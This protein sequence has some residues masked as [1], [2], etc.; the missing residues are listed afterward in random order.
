MEMRV[1]VIVQARMSSARFPGKV[2]APLCG[3]PLIRHVCQRALIP[4]AS[5][6]VATSDDGMDD[7]IYQYVREILRVPVY[8]GSLNNPLERIL[9][10]AEWQEADYV[11]RITGDTPLVDSRT[12]VKIVDEIQN[13]PCEYVGVTNSPDGSDSE[14][15]TISVLRAAY[16]NA[17]PGEIEHTTT[18]IRKNARCNSVESDPA[19]SDVH[20]SVN[21]IEDL[22]LCER[23][24]ERCGI[25]A[26]WQDYVAAYRSLN[27]HA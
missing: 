23:M 11:V 25:G 13:G 15:M 18:W 16:E 8:R 6:V 1:V 3:K 2:L 20:Y 7:P 10:A 9:R 17:G 24:I 5:L 22:R 14:V 12:I 26:R 21:T 19:Y 4:N 27:V